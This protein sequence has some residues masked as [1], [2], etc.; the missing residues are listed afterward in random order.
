MKVRK[1]NGSVQTFSMDKIRLTLERVSDELNQPLTGSDL[2]LLT[3]EIEKEINR[4]GK[5][6]IDSSEIKKIV[7]EILER[8]SFKQIA[9]AYEEFDKK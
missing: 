1:R 5:E 3:R 7:I 8:L 6:I 2:E 9:K 4:I